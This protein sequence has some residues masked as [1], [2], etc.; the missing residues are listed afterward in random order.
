[1]TEPTHYVIPAHDL[2]MIA[3]EMTS[4]DRYLLD[5]AIPVERGDVAWDV[6]PQDTDRF[7]PAPD[8]DYWREVAP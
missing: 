7:T 1:V 6:H 3:D 8:G 2:D 5:I 4:R